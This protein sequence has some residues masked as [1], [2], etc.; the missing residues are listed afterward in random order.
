VTTTQEFTQPQGSFND[1][2]IAVGPIVSVPGEQS[3]TLAFAPDDQP[4]AVMLDFMNPV[5]PGWKLCAARWDAR[6]ILILAHHAQLD[7]ATRPK[8]ESQGASRFLFA[9]AG[10]GSEEAGKAAEHSQRIAEVQ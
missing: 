3:H 5:W 7:T 8:I 4:I 6:L 10:G 2:R 1:Q 9:G